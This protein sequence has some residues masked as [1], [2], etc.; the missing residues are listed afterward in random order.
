MILAV[1]LENEEGKGRLCEVNYVNGE[2]VQSTA[3]WDSSRRTVTSSL[4]GPRVA[5]NTPQKASR[6]RG[7]GGRPVYEA[8][9]G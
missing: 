1:D 2:D 8:G 6:Q 7:R 5:N 9:V 3:L 4:G